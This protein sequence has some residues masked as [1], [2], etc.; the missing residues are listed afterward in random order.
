MTISPVEA[1][2]AP[3]DQT[4]HMRRDGHVARGIAWLAWA[5]SGGLLLAAIVFAALNGG[6]PKPD[7]PFRP[8]AVAVLGVLVLV[9]ATVGA[10]VVTRHPRHSIGWLFC[11]A[12]V[13]TAALL[14]TD[15]YAEYAL[16]VEPGSLPGAR[17]SAWLSTSWLGGT[18][19]LL[20]TTF[21]LLL[22]PDGRLPSPRWRPAAWLA[23]ATIA[24]TAFGV[25][26]A[27]GG[28][29]GYPSVENP[30]GV[31]GAFGSFF[32][33][34]SDISDPLIAASI[35]ASASAMA[36]RFHRSTGIERLQLKWLAYAAGLLAPTIAGSIAVEGAGGDSDLVVF[37]IALGLTFVP[38][39]AGIAILRYRLYDIDVVIN[40]T[41]VY[42]ALTTLLAGTYLG[43]VLLFQLA[44][45]PLTQGSGVAIALSTLAVAALFRPARGRIQKGVDRRFYRRKY[46]AARTLERF[47]TRL[48]D[49]VGLDALAGE[50]TA[51]VGEAMQPAHVSLWLRAPEAP[52]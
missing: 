16:F 10:I 24:V 17:I 44:L 33:L 27:P 21:G 22:F 50:L 13:L 9:S 43:L 36:V 30:A 52:R 38:V 47:G 20:I 26:L 14:A 42:G 48:R 5:A 29:Y 37:V 41:L 15:G 51:V 23:G 32:G 28:L 49:E 1:M 34:L 18:G 12:G 39:A 31:G 35:V 2:Y 4:G 8:A 19:I 46:D 40:R 7:D 25:A 3:S 45:S 6:A 11:S